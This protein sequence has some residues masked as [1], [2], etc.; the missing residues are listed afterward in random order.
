MAAAMMLASMPTVETQDRNEDRWG[1]C[2][3]LKRMKV[4][5]SW[6][7]ERWTSQA[8]VFMISPLI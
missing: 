8:W 2:R 6:G 3:G 5:K 1:D 4:K 7:Q